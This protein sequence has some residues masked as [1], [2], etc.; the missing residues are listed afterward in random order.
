MNP[1]TT[2]SLRHKALGLILNG[3]NAIDDLQAGQDSSDLELSLQASTLGLFQRQITL[4]GFSVNA[5]DP[6]GLSLVRNLIVRANIIQ[7]GQNVPEPGMAALLLTAL[8]S[9]MLARRRK[10]R[11]AADQRLAA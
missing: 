5:D 9:A 3:W 10:A 6:T 2:M 4:D 11:A 8:G 7:P 1:Q